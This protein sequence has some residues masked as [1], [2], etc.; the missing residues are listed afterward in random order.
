MAMKVGREARVTRTLLREAIAIFITI[1]VVI[2]GYVLLNK[3]PLQYELPSVS[4]ESVSATVVGIAS[5]TQVKANLEL[6]FGPVENTNMHCNITYK[7]VNA[8]A[9]HS[10]KLGKYFPLYSDQKLVENVPVASFQQQGGDKT[11]VVV[12]MNDVTVDLDE[13]EQYIYGRYGVSYIKF[14]FVGSLEMK[15]GD[16][17]SKRRLRA[18]CPVLKVV[19]PLFQWNQAKR[20]HFQPSKTCS[21][22]GQLLY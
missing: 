18:K 7:H 12:R 17:T 8:I 16:W 10:S 1:G 4:L 14:E 11:T 9:F 2:I 21:L 13:Y 15:S 22:L 20:V 6:V 3:T 5:D 19:F